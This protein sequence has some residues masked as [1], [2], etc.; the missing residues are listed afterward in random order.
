M[1]NP[2]VVDLRA[3]AFFRPLTSPV[4]LAD[5]G[6][7]RCVGRLPL[8]PCGLRIFRLTIPTL[9]AMRPLPASP[10]ESWG[11]GESRSALASVGSVSVSLPVARS[12]LGPS[13][14]CAEWNAC[15]FA[16]RIT[17]GQEVFLNSQGYPPHFSVIHRIFLLS[18][19]MSTVNPQ[20]CPQN[21]PC[22]CPSSDNAKGVLPHRYPARK[23]PFASP[24]RSGAWSLTGHQ[25]K[26][27]L[28]RNE[29]TRRLNIDQ[30]LRRKAGNHPHR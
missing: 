11:S 1:R 12:L 24:L 25:P 2:P 8:H 13:P 22:F 20:G 28:S 4:V 7:C 9:R 21:G 16:S 15:H 26:H 19:P 6:R 14:S 30:L 10:P 17:A 18:T 23:N 3:L 5:G 29:R 27:L